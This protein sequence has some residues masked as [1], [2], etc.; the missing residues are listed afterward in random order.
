MFPLAMGDAEYVSAIGAPFAI[1]V[2]GGLA[3]ST[4]LTL[5][6]IPTFYS[7]LENSLEWF[8]GLSLRLKLI[9]LGLMVI[10]MTLT[11]FNVDS[12]L[13]QAIDLILIILLIP[14]GTWFMI[15]SLKKAK[16]KLIGDGDPIGIRIQNLVKIYD[17]ESKF[18]IEWES[19]KKIRQRAG[20]EKEYKT[21]KEFDYL[22][23]QMPILLFLAYFAFQ[24]LDSA[25]WALILGSKYV[26]TIWLFPKI[27]I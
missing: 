1:V 5:V 8:K 10:F 2:I 22:V 17:R 16:T 19:G 25:F 15:N 20:L 11:Y 26:G 13:W 4:L 18:S 24:Y 6:F 21:L 9:Q 14:G 23:W 7:G 3:V 12:G 27:Q